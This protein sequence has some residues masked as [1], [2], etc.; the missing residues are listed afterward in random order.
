MNLAP[1]KTLNSRQIP[2]YA[3]Y[4][5]A[6]WGVRDIKAMLGPKTELESDFFGMDFS[7]TL[8]LH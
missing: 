8:P 1:N 4:N 2:L 3:W 5:I 7:L 6:Y